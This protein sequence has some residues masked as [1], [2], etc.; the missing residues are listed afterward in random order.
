MSNDKNDRKKQ[1][2]I[3]ATIIILALA[4]VLGINAKDLIPNETSPKEDSKPYVQEESKPKE[5]SKPD[6]QEESKP[7]EDPKQNAEEREKPTKTIQTKTPKI[8]LH[9]KLRTRN[10]KI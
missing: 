1:G 8:D 3:L 9:D 7:K 5:D 2:K 10:Q 6:V 4:T